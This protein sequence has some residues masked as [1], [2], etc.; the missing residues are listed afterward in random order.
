MSVMLD[1]E[2][3]LGNESRYKNYVVA[4]ERAL[5]Q[6]E[7]SNEWMDLI[8]YL[9]RLKKVRLTNKHAH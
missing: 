2:I 1:E 5:K 3:R 8:R 4:I 7:G 9:D 6:F